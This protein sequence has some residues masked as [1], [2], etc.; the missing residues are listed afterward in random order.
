MALGAGTSDILRSLGRE[1]L[2]MIFAGIGIGVAAALGLSRLLN[3]L[4]FGLSP[5]DPITFVGA[6]VLIILMAL[7]A[8]LL[9]SCRAFRTDPAR[10]LRND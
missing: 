10:V 8:C 7:L 5:T 3:S 4:L 1:M 9:P 2:P 6:T